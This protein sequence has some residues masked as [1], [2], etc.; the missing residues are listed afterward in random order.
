MQS[1]QFEIIYSVMQSTYTE[2]TSIK[3]TVKI[4]LLHIILKE[5]NDSRRHPP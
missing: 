3:L 2:Y 4:K 1:Y 5:F